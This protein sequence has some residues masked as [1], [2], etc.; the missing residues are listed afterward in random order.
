MGQIPLTY[1]SIFNENKE[2]QNIHSESFKGLPEALETCQTIEWQ[3]QLESCN[4]LEREWWYGDMHI[5]S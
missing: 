5:G 2:N 3:G 4:I 1:A